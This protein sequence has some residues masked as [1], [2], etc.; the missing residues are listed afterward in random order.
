MVYHQVKANIPKFQLQ[1][2]SHAPRGAVRLR[3]VL[4]ARQP[5][6]N[7]DS[8]QLRSPIGV[9]QL[10][11]CSYLSQLSNPTN[12]SCWFAAVCLQRPE[13]RKLFRVNSN[14]VWTTLSFTHFSDILR[15]GNFLVLHVTR[16]NFELD[17][18]SSKR[19]VPK[20]YFDVL[21]PFVRSKLDFDAP[22]ESR[23]SKV[24]T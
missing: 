20:A 11:D 8:R 15:L 24:E 2:M 9:I 14:V 13:N 3:A 10:G 17:S 4:F 16:S 22:L 23:F 18:E 19:G 6:S 12:L 7:G 1:T 21:S 5:T